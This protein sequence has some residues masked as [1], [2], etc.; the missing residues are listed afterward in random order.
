MYLFGGEKKKK[1]RK[2]SENMSASGA[3][4]PVA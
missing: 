2:E 4:T 3:L 1:K